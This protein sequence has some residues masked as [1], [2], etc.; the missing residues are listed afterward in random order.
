MR[1]VEGLDRATRRALR[2]SPDPRAVQGWMESAAFV[3]WRGG[4]QERLEERAGGTVE[5]CD[6]PDARHDRTRR[7][8]VFRAVAASTASTVPPGTLFGGSPGH[9]PKSLRRSRFHP[10]LNRSRVRPR[11]GMGF[12]RSAS[13]SRRRSEERLTVRSR[14]T[15]DAR[16]GRET[17]GPSGCVLG[18][19]AERRRPRPCHQ[20]R[21]SAFS[22]RLWPKTATKPPSLYEG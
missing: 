9:G 14:A 8:G 21:S 18:A 16:P 6:E 17:R 12:C 5:R 3:S 7:A 2:P 20:A 22:F 4:W 11:K 19:H 1:S 15:S 13:R 10:T